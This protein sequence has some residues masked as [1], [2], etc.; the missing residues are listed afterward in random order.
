MYALEN[1]AFESHALESHAHKRY[2]YKNP[3]C[4]S[5]PPYRWKDPTEPKPAH[6][7]SY[8]LWWMMLARRTFLNFRNLGLGLSVTLPHRTL[9]TAA[10]VPIP[11]RI[12]V[13]QVVPAYAPR[14]SAYATMRTI[15]STQHMCN[16]SDFLNSTSFWAFAIA[17]TSNANTVEA[18]T[19]SRVSED[20]LRP[21]ALNVQIITVSRA[22]ILSL[23]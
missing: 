2:P 4:Y 20:S 16:V 18:F 9:M 14:V 5:T 1:H 6:P 12:C 17:A 21:N 8:K 11:C 23:A 7:L 22:R 3:F 15:N 10:S 13:P 19:I